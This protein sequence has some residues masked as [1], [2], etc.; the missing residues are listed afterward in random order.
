MPFYKKTFDQQ[1]EE[2]AKIEPLHRAIDTFVVDD[3]TALNALRELH[4]R[5]Q[6]LTAD[7]NCPKRLYFLGEDLCTLLGD[8]F[9]YYNEYPGSASALDSE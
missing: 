1:Y 7:Y 5:I 4:E 3:K 6:T 8:A 9:E 2:A